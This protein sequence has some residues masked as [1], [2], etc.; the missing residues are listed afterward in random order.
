MKRVLSTV[1]LLWLLFPPSLVPALAAAAGPEILLLDSRTRE[2]AALR[3]S[4]RLHFPLGTYRDIYLCGGDDA[5]RIYLRHLQPGTV[6]TWPNLPAGSYPVRAVLVHADGRETPGPVTEIVVHLGSFQ[7]PVTL[8]VGSQGRQVFQGFGVGQ[9]GG[10][11]WTPLSATQKAQIAQRL[12][13]DLDVKAL[14]L[15]FDF[16]HDTFVNKYLHTGLLQSALQHG[17]KELLLAP[18]RFPAGMMTTLSDGRQKLTDLAGY[19]RAIAVHIKRL[20]DERGVSITATGLINEPNGPNCAKYV[21]PSD[22]PLLVRTLRAELDQRGLQGVRIIAAENASCNEVART[23]LERIVGD[24]QALAAFG[25]AATHSYNM[26]ANGAYAGLVASHNLQYWQTE[27]GCLKGCGQND[28]N[29]RMSATAA[30][31][32]LNDLNFRVSH[33]FWFTGAQHLANPADNQQKLLYWDTNSLGGGNWL[34]TNYQYW[35]L[36][37]IVRNLPAG[38]RMRQ[39]TSS[40]SNSSMTY[41]YGLKPPLNAAAGV[42]PDGK[43]FVAVV[44]NSGDDFAVYDSLLRNAPQKEYRVTIDIPELSAVGEKRFRLFRSNQRLANAGLAEI[45]LKNGKAT[46]LLAPQELITLV[47]CL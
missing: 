3:F 45:T 15:W 37:Q 31:R 29:Y 6:Y 39:V 32:F 8:S 9:V 42:R 41:T 17:V 23:I 7:E 4:V 35:Y 43:W 25:G 34:R 30:A 5:G 46:V 22:Y 18:D 19:A 44:N 26:T 20:K 11:D 10:S 2:P 47:E 24:S 27:S 1:A 13:R 36:K 28:F 38:T 21:E 33:W 12:Y 40:L 16:N 14:R